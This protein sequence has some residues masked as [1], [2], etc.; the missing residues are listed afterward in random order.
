MDNLEIND[1]RIICKDS[2]IKNRVE[3]IAKQINSD[4]HGKELIIICLSNSATMFT[5]DLVRL[6]NIPISLQ[7][8]SFTSYSSRPKS[9]EV[10]I[11]LDVK[12]PLENRHVL[13]VEG[14]IISGRTPLYIKNILKMRCPL[15]IEICAIGQKIQSK[16]VDLD[17][18]YC[19]FNFH[20]E[21]IEGYGIGNGFEKVSK[22]LLNLNI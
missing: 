9:G 7:L 1:P 16:Q 5:S 21:L 11:T 2:V 10:Q 12:E 19:L 4:Y 8:I 22:H 20:D 18:K 17:I 6:I 14:M 13:L 15:S 3:E